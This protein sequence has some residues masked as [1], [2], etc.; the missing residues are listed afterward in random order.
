MS[1]RPEPK[2]SGSRRP[3]VRP[4]ND[5]QARAIVK[6]TRS[7]GPPPPIHT[8]LGNFGVNGNGTKDHV[9]AEEAEPLPVPSE[10]EPLVEV[11]A[12]AAPAT[13]TWN[14][15]GPPGLILLTRYAPEARTWQGLTATRL[16]Y[17]LCR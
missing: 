1:L 2:V 15:S 5:G 16:W 3:C 4:R 8:E 11:A 10:E 12:A 7:S 17:G 14:D 6:P 9:P 13:M